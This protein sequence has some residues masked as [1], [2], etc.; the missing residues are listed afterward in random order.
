MVPGEPTC[1]RHLSTHRRH[2]R[3]VFSPTCNS[4]AN[5]GQRSKQLQ[6]IFVVEAVSSGAVVMG[7]PR[8]LKRGHDAPCGVVV[9]S[10][11]WRGARPASAVWTGWLEMATNDYCRTSTWR[12]DASQKKSPTKMGTL[13]NY[14][15]GLQVELPLPVLCLTP[16]WLGRSGACSR[17]NF[18]RHPFAT[19]CSGGN[20]THF[21]SVWNA[22]RPLIPDPS[23]ACARR[24]STYGRG[25]FSDYGPRPHVPVIVPT[26]S[27]C[28]GLC[29]APL[30]QGT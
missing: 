10:R 19:E 5:A 1:Q 14:Q 26:G 2:A 25:I 22:L 27:S 11:G 4:S 6:G 15:Q 23:I 21:A 16:P 18:R 13:D 3:G 24:L 8:G 12:T 29:G 7:G 17:K 30:P 9:C 28:G 20:K